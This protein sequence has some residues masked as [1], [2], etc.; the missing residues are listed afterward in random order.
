MDQWI[1]RSELLVEHEI[2]LHRIPDDLIAYQGDVLLQDEHPHEGHGNAH[3]HAELKVHEEATK[4]KNIESIVIGQY[5]MET[6][7]FSPFSRRIL[8]VQQIVLLRILFK[9]FW[10]YGRIVETF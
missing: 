3:S 4:I 7:Y 1:K 8:Q 5:E 2:R 10:T 6:W 9:F